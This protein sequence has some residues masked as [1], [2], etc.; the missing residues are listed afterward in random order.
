[1]FEMKAN[2]WIILRLLWGSYRRLG[3]PQ[4]IP[5]QG[6]ISLFRANELSLAVLTITSKV[7]LFVL[8][9]LVVLRPLFPDLFSNLLW[10]L[11]GGW[12][13]WVS[14]GSLSSGFWL[15]ASKGIHKE[16]ETDGGEIGCFLLSQC[17]GLKRS[18]IPPSLTLPAH[19][20]VQRASATLD[21][22]QLYQASGDPHSL[23][24]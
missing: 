19:P 23:C 9:V 21:F 5:D 11:G 2:A 15:E 13:L 24:C 6:S 17:C 14:I 8:S 20:T 1:M 18:T 4:H 12:A 16:D 10:V 3:T 7:V 22:L